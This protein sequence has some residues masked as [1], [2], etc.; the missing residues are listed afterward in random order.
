MAN[1][2]AI[3]RSSYF[4]VRDHEAFRAWVVQRGLGLFEADDR[5][6]FHTFAIHSGDHEGGWP[7][8][9][10]NHADGE[11]E[12]IDIFEELADHILD[13]WCAILIQV[14]WEKLRYLT[15]NAILVSRN[16]IEHIDLETQM[17]ARAEALGLECT[18]VEY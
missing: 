11:D 15:G 3:A 18:G 5:E 4:P 14:G 1:Y 9:A 8:T 7:T 12:E 17:Q 10:F 6:E 2:V 13:G 16:L